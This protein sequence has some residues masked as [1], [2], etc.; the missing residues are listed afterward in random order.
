MTYSDACAQQNGM[1]LTD[2]G[3]HN[4][5]KIYTEGNISK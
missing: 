2:I 4:N 3:V 1:K 5:I